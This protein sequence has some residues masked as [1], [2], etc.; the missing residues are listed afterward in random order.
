MNVIALGI[1]ISSTLSLEQYDF[2]AWGSFA[3]WTII[4]IVARTG[5]FF[6]IIGLRGVM[7]GWANA[8]ELAALIALPFDLFSLAII[9]SV[10][11]IISKRIKEKHPEPFLGPDFNGSNLIISGFVAFY[12][13]HSSMNTLSGFIFGTTTSLFMATIVYM[14]ISIVLLTSLLSIDLHTKWHKVGTLSKDSLTTSA[15][16]A[17]TG[18]VIGYMYMLDP[19]MIVLVM[20]PLYFL[21]GFLDR[22]NESKLIYIDEKTGLYNYRYFDENLTS[23]FQ[24]AKKNNTSLS[25]VF[26]DMDYLRDINNSYGHPVGDRAIVAVAKIFE[27]VSR[28]GAVAARFG[29]E[30]FVMIVPGNSQDAEQLALSIRNRVKEANFML[31]NGDEL[32]LSISLGV[33]TYPEDCNTIEELVK[34]S[35]NAL[36]LAKNSGRDQVQVYHSHLKSIFFQVKA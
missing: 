29:G 17:L 20:L 24:Q 7:V 5:G 2:T 35:D 25:L 19:F 10:I 22:I 15:I 12:V 16:L 1:V 11:F 28:N 27:N 8:I 36:Y 32:R 13:Y 9:I 33:A 23:M 3:L 26:A 14:V 6:K 34:A 31:D 18:C 21:H 4:L 30:E